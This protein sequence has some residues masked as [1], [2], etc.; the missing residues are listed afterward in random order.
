MRFPLLNSFRAVKLRGFS[1]GDHAS[2]E[3]QY[4]DSY[5]K[6]NKQLEG[7]LLEVWSVRIGNDL[8]CPVNLTL[9]FLF[10]RFR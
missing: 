8:T 4:F 6:M 10:L 3:G 1:G 2:V 7:E 9:L 5:P